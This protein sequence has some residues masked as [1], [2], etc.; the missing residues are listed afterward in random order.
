VPGSKRIK[1]MLDYLNNNFKLS[2]ASLRQTWLI[3]LQPKTLKFLMPHNMINGV[4]LPY[5][6]KLMK[7]LIK[8]FQ[9]CVRIA[10]NSQII[11]HKC[12]KNL[13]HREWFNRVDWMMIIIKSL[14]SK[15]ISDLAPKL[16]AESSS[17]HS[18]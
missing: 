9:F 16:K 8:K 1:M 17:N 12:L 10:R 13:K 4:R 14:W 5:R 11:L 6:I 2:K 3:T 15:N 18:P 7:F